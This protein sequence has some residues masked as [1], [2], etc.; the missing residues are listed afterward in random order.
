MPSTP[1]DSART[2]TAT[3]PR[4]DLERALPPTLTIV[5]GP[6]ASALGRSLP[7][8]AELTIGREEGELALSDSLLSRRHATLRRVGAG[9]G[10]AIEDHSK[11]GTFV[12]GRRATEATRAAPG[13][14]IRV[15]A[16]LL[17]LDRGRLPPPPIPDDPRLVGRSVPHLE[18][19]HGIR[20]VAATPLSVLVFGE[21]GTGKELVAERLHATSRRSGPLVAVNCAA[22]APTLVESA[23][24]GLLAS[25]GDMKEGM[26]AF[27]EKRKPAFEGE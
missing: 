6:D 19:L 11:N 7:L 10:F 12:D 22:L 16:T 13:S 15:G 25:T 4:R 8:G 17:Y 24:F 27:L 14:V 20:T 3:P 23:L 21:T 9:P 1:R 26:T 2:A 18:V 5:D